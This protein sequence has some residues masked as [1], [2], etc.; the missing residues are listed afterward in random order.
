MSFFAGKANPDQAPE[1]VTVCITGC[2]PESGGVGLSLN[3]NNVSSPSP[4]DAPAR[5]LAGVARRASDPAERAPA[6]LPWQI[7]L[8]LA[9]DSAAALSKLLKVGDRVIACDGKMLMGKH[10]S[11]LI[12]A[13]DEHTFVIERSL[14]WNGLS[15]ASA[16][17]PTAPAPVGPASLPVPPTDRVHAAWPG[18]VEEAAV[19]EEDVDGLKSIEHNRE[20]IVQKTKGQIG[21]SPEVYFPDTTSSGVIKIS[22]AR[23]AAAMPLP[24][25]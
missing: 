15:G 9:E 20:V 1:V 18:A 11:T 16:P 13:A 6:S 3:T 12:Q 5:R 8:E 23:R 25:P 24:L 10:L 2:K 14:T 19:E 4:P 22:K 7:I 21:I 17:W